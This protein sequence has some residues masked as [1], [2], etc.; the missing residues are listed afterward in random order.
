MIQDVGLFPHQN[1]RTNIGTVPRLLGWDRARTN[2]RADE[3]LSRPDS[4]AV[5]DGRP[6]TPAAR[7]TTHSRRCSR[8]TRPRWWRSKTG[9]R[10]VW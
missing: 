4:T 5:A 9:S 2:A 8:P 1:I 10:W 3:L 7:S 6:W